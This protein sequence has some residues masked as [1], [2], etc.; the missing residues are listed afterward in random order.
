MRFATPVALLILLGLIPFIIWLGYPR[1]P[2]RRR[3]DTASLMLRLIIIILLVLGL[4]GLQ[5]VQAAE[6]L[7]VVFLVDASDS[8]D[9]TA[10]DTAENYIRDSLSRISPD[11]RVGIV[12][13]GKNALVERPVSGVKEFSGITSTT[14]QLDT[15]IAEAIRLGLAMFPNDSARRLVILSDGIETLDSAVEAA[16]LAAAT[17]VQIDVLPLRRAPGPEVLVSEVRVPTTV[18]Q[19]ELFDLGVTIE[20]KTATRAN[21]T[22]L[23]GGQ[24]IQTS[25]VDLDAGTNNFVLQLRSPQQGF[26]DFQVRV[27]PVSGNATDTYYQNNQLAAF[28]EVTGPPRVLIVAE[29]PQEAS[30][31]VPSMQEAGL[32][33]DIQT[34]A[35]LP[36]GLA[37][38]A[39]T[40]R[41]FW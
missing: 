12:V 25:I 7:S 22:I 14:I 19:G 1:L 2:Y 9:Q 37:P 40:R 16:R 3:R 32:T 36:L 33:V 5:T 8:L 21:L 23:S 17:N 39:L 41:W 6:K 18:N 20:S 26:T 15:N 34:P 13:F 31:L 4:A 24:V 28:T 11:D 38:L 30:A 35:D 10:R 27:D 29:D